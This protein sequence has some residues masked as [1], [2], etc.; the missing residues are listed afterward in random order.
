MRAGGEVAGSLE[1]GDLD[2]ARRLLGWHL[3][4][5]DVS[6]LDESLVAAADD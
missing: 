6:E 2:G 3:V 4:S 5:R 1:R